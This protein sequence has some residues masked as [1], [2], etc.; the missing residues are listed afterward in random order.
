MHKKLS[1][2]S[3]LLHCLVYFSVMMIKKA[4]EVEEAGTVEGVKRLGV[5]GKTMR[6]L[7]HLKGLKEHGVLEASG[8]GS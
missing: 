6:C 2:H 3:E 4:M 5:L 1:S 7:E 8:F